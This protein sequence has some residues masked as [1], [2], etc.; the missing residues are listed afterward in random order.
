MITSHPVR[1]YALAALGLGL[2]LGCATKP[3]PPEFRDEAVEQSEY[4]VGAAD[5]VL[6]R[7]W[8]S[9]EAS[10]EAPVLPDG[11]LTVP[12]AGV[13]AAQGLTTAELEDAI[14]ERLAE[15]ITA[16]EVSVIVQQ[17]NSKRASVVGEV[18]RPG[19][20][21]VGA[22]TRVVEALSN[23]G[24]FTAFADR[25]HV[26]II[27]STENGEKE[28]NF[29]YDAYV[30]AGWYGLVGKKAPGTNVRLQPGD[31]VVVPD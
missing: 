11:T 31:V 17:I 24:G 6:V 23:A 16:P 3:V 12:L 21:G 26:K 19:F 30:G 15:Y 20:V 29:N 9:P 18:Q 14:A 28:F 8:K 10:V 27:R 5:L 22:N 25:T 4:R 7:V 13:I 2:A 1:A